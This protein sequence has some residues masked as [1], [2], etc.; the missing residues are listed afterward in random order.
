[1][2]TVASRDLRNR[3]KAVLA[4]DALIA[5]TAIAL[6]VPVVTQDDD[7]TDAPCL[8]VVRV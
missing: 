7:S 2:K 5:A 1:M 8:D 6:G 4:S 3:T